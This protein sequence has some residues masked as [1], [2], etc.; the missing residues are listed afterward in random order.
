[1]NI[2][3]YR[4]Y[5]MKKTGVTE[6]FPFSNIPDVLVFKVAGKMFTATDVSTFASISVKCDPDLVDELRARYTAVTIPGYMSKRHWNRVVMD[7]SVP[8]K[9]L[10]EWIDNSYNMVVAKLPKRER[11]N[12]HL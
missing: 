12:L 5:C 9:L 10:Y 1:M 11:E 7:N 6:S 4:N 2:E 8:D 3:A